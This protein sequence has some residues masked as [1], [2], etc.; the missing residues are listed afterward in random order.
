VYWLCVVSLV[1]RRVSGCE[2][3][4]RFFGDAE[5]GRVACSEAVCKVPES[6]EI[7]AGCRLYSVVVFGVWR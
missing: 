6:V 1:W 7:E 5:L 2:V 3:M 4:G